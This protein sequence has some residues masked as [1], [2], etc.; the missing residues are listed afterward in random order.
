MTETVQRRL[1]LGS[2]SPY[3]RE[4]VARLRIPF[5]VAAPDVDETDHPN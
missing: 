5:E 3:R 4:L 1:M 2:T